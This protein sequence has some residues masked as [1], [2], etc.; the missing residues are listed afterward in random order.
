MLYMCGTQS[1][2]ASK[3]EIK[4]IVDKKEPDVGLSALHKRQT[5]ELQSQQQIFFRFSIEQDPY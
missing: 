4:K 5:I 2:L 1:P 3:K